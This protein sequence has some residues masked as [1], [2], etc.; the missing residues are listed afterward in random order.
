MPSS[1]GT[2][3][4]RLS[5]Y[6]V[7]EVTISPDYPRGHAVYRGV[8]RH[9]GGLERVEG[10]GEQRGHG[11]QR[12]GLLV[13]TE[14]DL[15]VKVA[16]LGGSHSAWELGHNV[17]RKTSVPGQATAPKR[18]LSITSPSLRLGTLIG[19]SLLWGVA[20]GVR[21]GG[22]ERRTMVRLSVQPSARAL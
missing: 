4:A 21:L 6:L 11:E 18:P 14:T 12:Q 5:P 10:L 22:R 9:G 17:N 2:F 16:L 15:S 1:D 13:A 19:C 8:S 7:V 3:L 20:V